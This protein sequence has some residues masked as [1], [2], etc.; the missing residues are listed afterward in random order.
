MIRIEPRPGFPKS[1]EKPKKAGAVDRPG[2]DLGGS[3]G[4]TTAGT[5]L[6]LGDNAS[7]DPRDRSLPGR[8]P[9]DVQ[10]ARAGR[11]ADTKNAPQSNQKPSTK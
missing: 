2:L 1:T 6:G 8:R 5:G 3:T 9:G 10:D 7:E 11:D 4:E